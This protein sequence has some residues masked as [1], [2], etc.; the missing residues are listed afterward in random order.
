MRTLQNNELN[1]LKIN[2]LR[3]EN[4]CYYSCWAHGYE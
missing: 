2:V 3:R 1:K 4:N